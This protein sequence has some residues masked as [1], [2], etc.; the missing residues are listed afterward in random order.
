MTEPGFPILPT[1]DSFMKTRKT[2]WKAVASGLAATCLVLA[3]CS[4]ASSP[5]ES[6]APDGPIYLAPEDFDSVITH[7]PL[8][9][10]ARIDY[11]R[12]KM[13]QD[14]E[15]TLAVDPN[16]PG[17]QQIRRA[18]ADLD[19][20]E[21]QLHWSIARGFT[22]PD[23]VWNTDYTEEEFWWA[24]VEDWKMLGLTEEQVRAAEAHLDSILAAKD[25]I[26][27]DTTVASTGSSLCRAAVSALP[28]PLG[29]PRSC[30]RGDPAA[31]T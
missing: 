28:L 19:W 21:R 2:L 15:M 23:G 1:E 5:P 12:A 11:L 29:D 25:S 9:G 4:S 17:I 10:Q 3:G 27:T 13:E 8:I 18:L 16:H 20:E 7:P 22:R 31:R 24:F 6:M 26:L 14:L 30:V